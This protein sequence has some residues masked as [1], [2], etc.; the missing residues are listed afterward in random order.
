M[1]E[2]RST[3]IL[4]KEIQEDAR[5]KAERIL[6]NADAECK[7]ILNDVSAKI[8]AV[9]KEKET[10]YEEKLFQV[11]KDSE[12]SVPLEKERFLVSFEGKV[13]IEAI[14]RYLKQLDI[15]KQLKLIEKLLNRYKN[16]FA[17]KKIQSLIFGFEQSDV[18]PLLK[19]VFGKSNVVSCSVVAFNELDLDEPEGLDVHKGVILESEDRAVRCRATFAEI[20]SEILDNNSLELTQTL[21]CGRLPQ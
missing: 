7:K 10:Y 12:A 11:K 17:D 16:I 5:K 6:A 19:S 13:V 9:K 4:D 8:S 3:E 18:E 2:L 1:E 21:F 15:Q 14:N 20:V